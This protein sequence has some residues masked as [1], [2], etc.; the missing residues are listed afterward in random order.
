[1]LVR[2]VITLEYNIHLDQTATWRKQFLEYGM[3]VFSKKWDD[4]IAML[5]VTQEK[6]FKKIGVANESV[7]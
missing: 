7:K 2:V 3:D 1:M 4:K 5:E 6:L